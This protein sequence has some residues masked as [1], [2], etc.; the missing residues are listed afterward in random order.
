MLFEDEMII[1]IT[2]NVETKMKYL[3]L[4]RIEYD[5]NLLYLF[6]SPLQAFILPLRIFTNSNERDELIAFIKSKM[7]IEEAAIH[8]Q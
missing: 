5:N 7:P 2:T 3:N 6:F 8:E 1:D 4:E